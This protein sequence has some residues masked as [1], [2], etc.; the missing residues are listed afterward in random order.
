MFGLFG[1][2]KQWFAPTTMDMAMQKYGY[3]QYDL[4]LKYLQW[5]NKLDANL[6]YN[7]LFAA[8]HGLTLFRL[9]K[10]NATV[11]L[12]RS[13]FLLRNCQDADPCKI[14]SLHNEIMGCL[15]SVKC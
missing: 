11:E 1:Q 4:A 14:Q 12:E 9:D 7:G 6:G 13:L 8:Y 2:I 3:G 5:A 15:G 10:R